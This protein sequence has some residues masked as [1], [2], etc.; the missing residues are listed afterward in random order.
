ML[1][2][3]KTERLVLRSFKSSD[4]DNVYKGLSNPDI[5]KYYGISFESK[6]SAKEQM[7]WFANHEKNATGA[8]WA[9]CLKGSGTFV[10]AGGLNDISREHK[11]AEFG[12]WLLPEYWGNEFMGEAIP[13][14]L[15]YGFN[16]LNLNRIEGFVESKNANCKKALQKL[17]FTHEGTKREAE[18]KNNAF[19]DIDIYSKLKSDNP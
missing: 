14:I 4:L 12:V 10:G 7:K 19:I 11:S 3:I 16:E 1:P 15:N 18:F 6:E 2:S 8:W 9:I 5:I 13:E 17:G